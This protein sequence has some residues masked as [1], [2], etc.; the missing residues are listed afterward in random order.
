MAQTLNSTLEVET[1]EDGWYFEMS[2]E[3]G[4][5]ETLILRIDGVTDYTEGDYWVAGSDDRCASNE[6]LVPDLCLSS[7]SYQISGDIDILITYE[8]DHYGVGTL[9]S[10]ESIIVSMDEPT[11][12]PTFVPVASATINTFAASSLL[13]LA[14]CRS[15]KEALS[16]TDYNV[17]CV[18]VEATEEDNDSL[19]RRRL[20]FGNSDSSSDYQT[21]ETSGDGSRWMHAKYNWTLVFSS[22]DDYIGTIGLI[23]EINN[24][25]SNYTKMLDERG[26]RRLTRSEFVENIVRGLFRR[27]NDATIE[28]INVTSLNA[29]YIPLNNGMFFLKSELA[30]KAHEVSI[31]VSNLCVSFFLW[32]KFEIYLTSYLHVIL[33]VRL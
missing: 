4:T 8:S 23:D 13:E 31:V 25:T 22:E 11:S 3:P 19:V 5:T 16:A 12:Q 2:I 18:L 28:T 15:L 9:D 33:D 17:E 14:L 32:V 26:K 27:L 21:D 7:L 30:E 6:L 29:E 1:Y 20:V 10:E 24:I